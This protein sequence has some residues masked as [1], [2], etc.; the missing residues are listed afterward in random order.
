MPA[1]LESDDLPFVLHFAELEATTVAASA[2]N[3]MYDARV[4]PLP[5]RYTN[6]PY[7]HHVINFGLLRFVFV[8]EEPPE[9][10]KPL[11]TIDEVDLGEL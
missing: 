10:T 6:M 5:L 11:I 7:K 2:E 9:P 4:V 1:Y 3:W 8:H